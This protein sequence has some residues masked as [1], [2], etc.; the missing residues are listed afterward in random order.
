M[1]EGITFKFEGGDA[2]KHFIEARYYGA[3][4][5]GLDKA[6]NDALLLLE[7]GR[8]PKRGERFGLYIVAK[9]PLQ[10]SVETPNELRE[11]AWALPLVQEFIVAHGREF[12]NHFLSWLLK[13]HG[14]RK[15]E[16]LGH[17]DKMIEMVKEVNRHDEAENGAWRE[18]FLALVDKLKPAAQDIVAPVGRSAGTLSIGSGPTPSVVVDE[19]MA[20]AIRS[21]DEIEVLDMEEMT[22][23]IDGILRHNRQLKVE[24]A[25]APGKFFAADVRDPIFEVDGNAYISAF[26]GNTPVTVQAKKA[27]KNGE[28]HRIYV[29]NFLGVAA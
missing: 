5:I 7:R 24:F 6:V 10:G 4:L 18:T 8:K 13:W 23:R 29:M 21:K 20:D 3:S 27:L 1:I 9:P 11:I 19:P 15:P 17:M 14:G 28:L 26:V 2:D 22:F 25:D 16:A 12:L